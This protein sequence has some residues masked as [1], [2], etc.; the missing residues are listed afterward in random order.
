MLFLVTAVFFAGYVA[1]T[2]EPAEAQG[3]QPPETDELFSPFWETWTLLHEN[4]VDPLDDNALMEGAITGMMESLNDPHSGYMSPDLFNRINESMS[5]AYEGIGAVVRQ[6][7]TTGGLELV[8]IMDNSPAEKSGLVPGDQIVQVAGEDVT[9]KTQEE[10]IGLV[11]GPAGTTVQ[12]G[13]LRSSSGEVE[14]IDVTR[15]R[16]II[17]SVSYEI[18]DNNIGYLRLSQFEANSSQEMRDALE[19]MDANNLDGLILD[20]RGNPGGYLTTAIEV[21][22]AYIQSGTVVTERGP[23]REN[24]YTAL[25]DAIAPDVPM[26]VLVD[27]GSASASELIAGALHDHERAIIIGMQTFGKG[28][29]Q[30]WQ[31]LSNGGGVRITIS[32]WYTPNGTS[33]SEVGIT[34]D[35]VIPYIPDENDPEADNQLDAAITFFAEGKDAVEALVEADADEAAAILEAAGGQQPAPIATEPTPEATEPAPDA[36][37]EVN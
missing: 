6:N 12:L 9:Q 5:G 13:I 19:A 17:P 3:Q 27:Q 2:R 26:V 18:L 31:T 34:P 11:R 16:V 14:Q 35:Y 15:D 33:V 1:G 21:A 28:S 24:V 32:R 29:V 22:S 10:I 37:P 36:T 8:T 7:E 30:T 25:E 23:D 4:Y 20:V